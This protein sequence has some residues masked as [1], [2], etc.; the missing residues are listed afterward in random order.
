MAHISTTPQIG[1][2][3]KISDCGIR[4]GNYFFKVI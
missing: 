2:L 3:V 4:E 1:Q